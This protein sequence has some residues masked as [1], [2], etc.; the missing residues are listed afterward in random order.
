MR[1][2]T[3]TVT[4][5]LAASVGCAAIWLVRQTVPQLQAP[6]LPL[7]L[8]VLGG[9]R[10]GG[11]IAH[12]RH[13]DNVDHAAMWAMG[14]IAAGLWGWQSPVAAILPGIA[15]LYAWSTWGMHKRHFPQH[16][17]PPD[18]MQRH[19]DAVAERP[20]KPLLGGIRPAYR[21]PDGTFR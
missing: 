7:M 20:W 10:L 1:A 3:L 17:P 5:V 8:A 19:A 9:I 2:I 15:A 21:N 14:F 16:W 18:P 6:A 12:D 4:F 13:G 11:Y